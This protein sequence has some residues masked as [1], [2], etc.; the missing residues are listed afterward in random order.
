M[1]KVRIGVT[2]MVACVGL[3]WA[4]VAVAAP[5]P[6]M[7]C[8]IG[9]V[10]AAKK[11]EI[12]L[13]GEKERE[14]KGKP[15]DTQKCEDEFDEKI[16][17]ADTKAVKKGVSCRFLNN[18]DGTTTDLNTLRMWEN[19]DDNNTGG[20]HDKD[21]FFTWTA[22]TTAPDGTAFTDFLDTLNNTCNLL[23]TVS[24]VVN[25]DCAVAN[26]GPGGSCGF[27]GYRD[28]RLAEVN[29]HGGTGEL[30]SIVDT[31]VPGCAVA[32]FNPCVD[33]VFN[34]GC[35]AA[36]TLPDCSC[37]AKSNYWSS[38]SNASNPV[39]AWSVKFLFGNV[40]SFSKNFGI[41]ARAVRGGR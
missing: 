25:A 26:G 8:Q 14:L 13:A 16:A 30:E 12:C 3:L 9:K 22:G 37:T 35:V 17:K 7:K 5:D 11:R 31:T 39:G 34:D 1:R 21:T 23:E 2:V 28:W 6:V 18:G 10:L 41:R 24:C 27:A 32:P 20:I 29:R 36:C 33:P 40:N 19:K 15:F 38:I 4:G